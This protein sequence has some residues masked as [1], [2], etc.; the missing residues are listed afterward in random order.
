MIKGRELVSLPVVTQKERKY[1]GEVKDYIYDPYQKIIMGYL[2]ENVG[3]LRDGKGFLHTDLIKHENDCLIVEDESVIRN[4]GTILELK[5][6][7]ERKVDIRGMQVEKD[8]GQ[9][10]GVVEDLVLDSQTGEIT[11]YEISDGIIQDLLDGR[12][13]IPNKGITINSDR[14]VTSG[15][16]DNES[17]VKGESVNEL[18]GL[19]E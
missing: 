12:A 1:L 16:L 19:W 7:L 17:K 10:I 3:W 6:V 8:N 18:S 5:E 15:I 11:G 9:Y 2:V 4:I 14:V 13:I